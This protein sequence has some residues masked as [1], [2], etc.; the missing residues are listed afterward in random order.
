M[1]TK[2]MACVAFAAIFACILPV[3]AAENENGITIEVGRVFHGAS[4][5]ARYYGYSD[6]LI[7]LPSKNGGVFSFNL[8]NDIPL[9]G[10]SCMN[11]F[12]TEIAGRQIVVPSYSTS[13]Q[14]PEPYVEDRGW[15]PS[16]T[17]RVSIGIPAGTTSIR[18]NNAQSATGIELSD[19]RFAESAATPS[20]GFAV[21]IVRDI[22]IPVIEVGRINTG[23]QSGRKFYGYA[24]GTIHLPSR[25]GG[26]LTFK[27]WNDQRVGHSMTLNKLNLTV[28]GRKETF[29]QY[30]TSLDLEEFYKEFDNDYGPAG[31]G[32][33]M[34]QL[35][36]GIARVEFDNGGSM[37]GIELSDFNYST[38]APVV[39]TFKGK[40]NV[41]DRVLVDLGRIFNGATSARKYYG[42]DSGTIIL[43]DNGGGTLTFK[44]WNDHPNGTPAVGNTLV[45]KAGSVSQSFLLVSL[46]QDRTEVY[47]EDNGWGPGS[48]KEYS[49]RVPSGVGVVEVSRGMSQTGIELS[50]LWYSPG[51]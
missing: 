45:L 41:K 35:P 28:G 36:P 20:G 16:G 13:S 9:G 49:F 8:W 4:T 50:D 19:L 2:I 6:G 22:G 51:R 5:G 46:L 10:T 31:G 37:T 40:P 23:K 25:D 26:Y 33:V 24:G 43:P 44:L 3:S 21:D 7:T 29:S 42:Y 32:D 15:G 17:Q 30:T 14:A 38:G 18:F 12:R 47:K 11:Y 1:K 39:M 48:G 34:I 27:L